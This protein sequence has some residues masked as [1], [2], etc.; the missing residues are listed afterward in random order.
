MFVRNSGRFLNILSAL[1]L[2]AAGA[3]ARADDGLN[4]AYAAILRGDYAGGDAILS[5]LRASAPND[6]E[7]KSAADWLTAFSST[8]LQ[9]DEL[10]KETF[11]WD[12][13]QAQKAAAD[14][15]TYLALSFASQAAQYADA[16]ET[17]F[18]EDWFQALRTQALEKAKSYADASKWTRAHSYYWLLE[19][20]NPRDE[21]IKTLRDQAGRHVRL[22]VIYAK[23]ADLDRRIAGVNDRMLEEIFKLVSDHYYAQPD[24]R[25]MANGAL[26]NLTAL[27][28][29]TKLYETLDGIATKPLRESFLGRIEQKR[30]EIAG[31]DKVT[32]DDLIRL[33]R[34]VAAANK[35]LVELPR[36]LV[37]VEFVEGALEELDEFTSVIWPA[38]ENDFDKLMRGEFKGVGIQLGSDELTGRLKVV[39]PLE[40]S[41]ALEKGIR[42]NDLII[43][44]DGKSTKGW[45][46]EDAVHEITGTAG[47]TVNLTIYRPSTGKTLNYPLV[48]RPISLT[49]V[50]GVN[51]LETQSS[52]WNYML[53]PQAGIAYIQLT[54]FNPDSTEELEQALKQ[55][56]QQGMQGL[57][58]DLRG[59][60]GGL[61]E[62]AIGITSLFQAKGEVVSTRG[63]AE[64][65]QKHKVEG[66]APYAKL[67][68]VVLVNDNSASASEI[69]SG[70]L[71]DHDRAMVLGSRTFGKGSV[72]RV[73]RLSGNAQLKLTTALYY[74]PKGESP[75]K[76]P[77]ALRAN[78]WGVSPDLA[79]KITPKEL[80]KI[81][82]RERKAFII[83]N[84]DQSEESADE[85]ARKA[86]LE[87][88]KDSEKKGDADAED[89]A[90]T[91]QLTADDIK[92]IQS[93]PF[94]APDEDPQLQMALLELRVKL[95]A[96]LPWPRQIASAKP[97][98]APAP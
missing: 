66:D 43:E 75:H 39:T 4:S 78:H 70:A 8:R 28:N 85:D 5:K 68:L 19:R 41:P 2:V 40:N 76:T 74:L 15:K 14:K 23:K 44:V 45:S 24:F 7:V 58:L 26:N 71:Q 91:E 54:G 87:S 37:T 84:E 72:Q 96:N 93:D 11:K 10:T 49:S 88:L 97:E 52:R 57:I 30:N 61:L 18:K 42:P 51:R 73:M 92:Q 36:G 33:Y 79:L 27:V 20:I 80:N 34:D 50:R 12:V 90:D 62:T 53:D 65:Q 95:A 13:E 86:G 46:T 60:P 63:R 32:A 6:A 81:Y 38:D 47:T 64:D 25:K 35:E 22:E 55:A 56:K 77:E 17:L 82:E 98:L 31:K 83:H 21:E 1:V 94:K 89:D 48:R 3:T 9:R 69:L 16:P 67:P 29:T 59:N